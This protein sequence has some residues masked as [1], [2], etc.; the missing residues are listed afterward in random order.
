MNLLNLI[1]LLLQI[2]LETFLIPNN[3][4]LK[5]ILNPKFFLMGKYILNSFLISKELKNKKNKNI[6]IFLL[7]TFEAFTTKFLIN[8]YYPDK[9]QIDLAL[10][11]FFYYSAAIALS[12]LDLKAFEEFE[13]NEILPAILKFICS[14]IFSNV[15][16]NYLLIYHDNTI[17]SFNFSFEF[18]YYYFEL[19]M[20][21]FLIVF[22]I[23]SVCNLINYY[24]GEDENGLR[25]ILKKFL[26]KFFSMILFF[27][28][29]NSGLSEFF[30]D[31]LFRNISKP[32]NILI[33]NTFSY[34]GKIRMKLS[35]AFLFN[36]LI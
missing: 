21:D 3:N 10:I 20:N 28:I 8:Y 11:L 13:K 19:F 17:K 15:F 16:T 6:S 7:T 1:L 33:Y 32:Y 35:F 23:G 2:F 30:Y 14:F 4:N 26:V 36:I 9:P 5:E 24:Y 12:S 25:K 18:F 27:V 22:G 29:F 34:D 31:L